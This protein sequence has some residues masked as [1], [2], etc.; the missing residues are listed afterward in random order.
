MFSKYLT[1]FLYR[2]Q[3]IML[4]LI[5]MVTVSIDTSA[6]SRM[7]NER[8]G[9][10]RN[11]KEYRAERS[12]QHYQAMAKDE[13]HRRDVHN[14]Q[15]QNKRFGSRE[16]SQRYSNYYKHPGYGIVYRQFDHNPIVFI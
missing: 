16:Y 10:E 13:S 2:T 6:E 14:Y 3:V 9:N 15:I 1:S 4:I 11:N 8:T 5:A 12:S 7:Y